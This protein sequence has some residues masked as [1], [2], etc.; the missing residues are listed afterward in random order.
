MTETWI[1]KLKQIAAELFEIDKEVSEIKASLGM[2]KA[3]LA[4]KKKYSDPE[5]YFKKCQ[6]LDRLSALR[7]LKQSEMGELK[8]KQKEE[9]QI[10]LQS[11][12]IEAAKKTLD[13]ETIQKIWDMVHI[14]D[15][16]N[17]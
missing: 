15:E 6:R 4:R 11:R 8:E 2:A 5:W 17:D 1:E 7:Q 9:R 3:K 12:F 16:I 10:S 14:S 13:T